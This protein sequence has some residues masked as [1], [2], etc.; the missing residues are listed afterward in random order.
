MD[1]ISKWNPKIFIFCVWNALSLIN[2]GY[3]FGGNKYKA[4][5]GVKPF[6]CYCKMWYM[7]YVADFYFEICLSMNRLILPVSLVLMQVEP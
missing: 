6:T 4:T 7:I 1:V 3:K 5:G 2:I